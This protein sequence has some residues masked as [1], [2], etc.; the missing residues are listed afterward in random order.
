MAP[1]GLL[2][3][4]SLRRGSGG[5]WLPPQLCAAAYLGGWTDGVRRDVPD[6][7]LDQ[8]LGVSAEHW[9]PALLLLAGLRGACLRVDDSLGG[10]DRSFLHACHVRSA[11][12]L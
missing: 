8:R 11:R 1:P 9:R 3:A 12:A 4:L 5:H 7:D 10:P 6:G 2:H